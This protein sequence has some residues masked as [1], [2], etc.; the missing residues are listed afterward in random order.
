MSMNFDEF[1]G[2][3]KEMKGILGQLGDKFDELEA[4]SNV[5][6]WLSFGIR[7]GE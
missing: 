4:E 3:K 5:G 7:T 2:A 6:K 1:K